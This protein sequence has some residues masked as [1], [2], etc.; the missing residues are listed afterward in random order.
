MRR[1]RAASP[2][3]RHPVLA[4][5]D[6]LPT[7]IR[8]AVD[9]GVPVLF[10]TGGIHAADF[11]PHADPDGARV[12]AR[13][14][15]EGLSAVAYIPSCIGPGERSHDRRQR[16]PHRHARRRFPKHGAEASWRSGISTACI[17]AIRQCCSRRGRRPSIRHACLML[18]FEPH[19][20]AFFSGRPLFRLTPAPLKA[21]LAAAL[22]LDG[23]LVLD[24]DRA[25]AE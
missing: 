16:I 9:N 10:V 8:G 4:V 3:R 22:G 7:D 2:S 14:K 12:A 17:A 11:G 19:P 25:L 23:T 6:G 24:F 18:T 15:A 1:R 5:G 21:A 13:L 20:R